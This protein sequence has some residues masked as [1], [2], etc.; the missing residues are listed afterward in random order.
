MQNARGLISAE[1]K[2]KVCWGST[3]FGG[4]QHE[5]L[6]P[7][8]LANHYCV[9]PYAYSQTIFITFVTMIERVEQLDRDLFL[10]LNGLHADWLDPIMWHLSSVLFMIP[11]FAFAAYYAYRKGG[12]RFTLVLLGGIGLCI[13]IADRISVEFFKEVFQRFRPTHNEDIGSLVHTVIDPNGNEYR[14]GLYG[15]VS[16]HATNAMAMSLFVFLHFRRYTNWWYF[17]FL[18]TFV[19]SYTRIYLGVHYPLD[20][21]CGGLLGIVIGG[22]VYWIS[23]KFKPLKNIK[24]DS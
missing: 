8:I 7:L 18:W 16:S 1:P 15:F 24:Y 21:L 9:L 23:L 22:F 3:Y 13:L 20:L 6:T 11:V 19:V 17:I 12:V 10:A 2:S 4:A 5:P 14:G